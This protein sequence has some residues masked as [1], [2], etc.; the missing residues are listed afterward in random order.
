MVGLLLLKQLKDL[1][2]EELVVQWKQNPYYQY[3]CGFEEF[4]IVEPCHSTDLVYF[5]MR[6]GKKGVEV[7]FK[8]SIQLHGKDAEE[9]RVI[10]DTT[11]QEK[12]IT[13]PTDGKLVIKMISFFQR[14]AKR[15]GSQLRRT[16]IKEIKG[17]RLSLRFFRHPKKRKK[18]RAAIKRLRTI[19]GVLIRDISRNLFQERLTE[20]Q[21][22]FDL[23]VKVRNQKMK[24]SNKVYDLATLIRI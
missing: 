11:V 1:S 24:D 22:T 12:N 7:I 17:H 10:I 9:K 18:A 2:A 4:Q 15:E 19:V 16:Y 21:E 6:I 3:F 8:M 13:Y 23:F 5:R 14:L 20:L